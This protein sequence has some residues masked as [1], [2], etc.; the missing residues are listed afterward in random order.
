MLS[1]ALAPELCGKTSPSAGAGW[2]RRMATE[3]N[4]CPQAVYAARR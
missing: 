3:W 4:S 1:M 2:R